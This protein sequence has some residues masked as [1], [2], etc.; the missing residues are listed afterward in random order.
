MCPTR[1]ER[2]TEVFGTGLPM[3]LRPS[4]PFSTSR[5]FG[6]G[7][8]T[9]GPVE[10]VLHPPWSGPTRVTTDGY[11]DEGP[12]ALGLGLRMVATEC[13]R[14]EKVGPQ[15][16]GFGRLSPVVIPGPRRVSQSSL[17]T[18]GTVT[19]GGRRQSLRV[20]RGSWPIGKGDGRPRGRRS[21]TKVTTRQVWSRSPARR[22]MG[23]RGHNTDGRRRPSPRSRPS[24][25]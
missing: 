25:R 19:R 1:P 9:F 14:P 13:V 5:T 4:H 11:V 22:G 18:S 21:G 6:T 15:T 7:R 23:S 17:P 24:C 8:C 3:E 20:P 2:T 10:F 12:V 16:V